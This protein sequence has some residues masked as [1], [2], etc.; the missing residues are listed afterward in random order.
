MPEVVWGTQEVGQNYR[1]RVGDLSRQSSR[2]LGQVDLKAVPKDLFQA[3]EIHV[4]QAGG[5]S[6]TSL[7]HIDSQGV[8]SKA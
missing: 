3:R 7:R 4:Q 5:L 2:C 6:V 8:V 1:M